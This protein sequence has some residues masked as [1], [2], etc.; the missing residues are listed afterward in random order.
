MSV[1]PGV[2]LGVPPPNVSA[3]VQLPVAACPRRSPDVTST[4]HKVRQAGGARGGLELSPTIIVHINRV[5][6]PGRCGGGQGSPVQL[7]NTK[8][9]WQRRWG[10]VR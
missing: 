8:P 10:H 3:T 4:R 7:S 6:S 1:H 9:S 5:P 2:G